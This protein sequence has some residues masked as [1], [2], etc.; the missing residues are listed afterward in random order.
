MTTEEKSSIIQM[1][2]AGRSLSDIA[3]ELGLSRNTVKS[4]C[5]RNNSTG[6]E[7]ETPVTAGDADVRISLCLYCGK[8]V[9]Q[10]PG[11]KLKKYCNDACRNHHWYAQVSESQH[12]AMVA[13]TCPVCGDRFFAYPNRHRKYCSHECY[14]EARFGGWE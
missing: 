14:I 12:A 6:D 1:R 10:H 8:P 3:E 9:Q 13:Y 4:F 11:H 7:N 5:R 2:R